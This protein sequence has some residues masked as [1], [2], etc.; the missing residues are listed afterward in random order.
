MC[1]SVN[2]NLFGR[3]HSE[4]S[5]EVIHIEWHYTLCYAILPVSRLPMP[6]IRSSLI[7]MKVCGGSTVYS[8]TQSKDGAEKCKPRTIYCGRSYWGGKGHGPR[9]GR[10]MDATGTAQNTRH[11]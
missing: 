6:S 4:K 9:H 3:N 8:R 1:V 11:E 10:P 2:C 7:C 5:F